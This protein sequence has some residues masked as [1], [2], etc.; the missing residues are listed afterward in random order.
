LAKIFFIVNDPPYG[1]ER[2][3]NALR[4]AINLRKKDP[5]AELRMF[6][7]GDG[8]SRAKSGQSVPQ[9]YY[10]IESMLKT[11]VQGGCVV[12]VC[13]TCIDARG[14][15]DT[16]LVEGTQRSSLNEMTEWTLWADKVLV[17]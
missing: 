12:G 4:L 7:V 17:F 15:K 11:V 9:G 5:S 3:Y 2:A 8:A 13:S 6:L 10:N 14:L 1:T 16:D